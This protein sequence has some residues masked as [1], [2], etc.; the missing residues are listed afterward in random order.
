MGKD[1]LYLYKAI[2]QTPGNSFPGVNFYPVKI[3]TGDFYFYLLSRKNTLENALR[4]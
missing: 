3:S 4:L 2:K 1:W